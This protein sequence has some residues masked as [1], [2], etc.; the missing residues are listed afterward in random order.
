M[1]IGL[2][3]YQSSACVCSPYGNTQSSCFCSR[4]RARAVQTA[5]VTGPSGAPPLPVLSDFSKTSISLDISGTRCTTLSTEGKK[6]LIR[7]RR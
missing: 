2:V 4:V 5:A 6:A 7:G 1:K 3:A